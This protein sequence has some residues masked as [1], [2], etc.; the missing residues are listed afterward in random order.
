MNYKLKA[1]FTEQEAREVIAAQYD[2][3]PVY[4]NKPRIYCCNGFKNKGVHDNSCT[5]L[6]KN[7]NDA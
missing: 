1:L 5:S 2:E 3:K 7:S 6:W 4:C